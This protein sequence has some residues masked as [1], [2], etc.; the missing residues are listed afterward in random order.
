MTSW[1]FADGKTVENWTAGHIPLQIF[2]IEIPATV[3]SGSI[4]PQ[5]EP[6]PERNPTELA[7]E[8][9]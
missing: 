4:T 1:R 5:P 9:T 8:E 3:P 7:E 2:G 6:I